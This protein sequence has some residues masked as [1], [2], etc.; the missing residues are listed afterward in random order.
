MVL[1][2]GGASGMGGAVFRGGLG[3]SLFPEA[4]EVAFDPRGGA[5]EFRFKGA[6][7]FHIFVFPAGSR[8][9][10]GFIAHMGEGLFCGGHIEFGLI[11]FD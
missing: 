11:E 4:E 1:G 8:G 10:E 2:L 5:W 6:V 3:L 7:E 9:L